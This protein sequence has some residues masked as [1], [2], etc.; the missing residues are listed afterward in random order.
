MNRMQNELYSLITGEYKE[1]ETELDLLSRRAF[2][3]ILRK[4]AKKLIKANG[5]PKLSPEQLRQVKEYY[6]GYPA[7]NPIYHQVNTGKSGRFYPEYIPEELYYGY[8]EPYFS[9][10]VETRYV[11]N[12][13][14]YYRMFAGF[15][16]PEL[17]CMR[18]RG[19]WFGADF[20]PVT[21]KE[22]LK[23][24]DT[25]AEVVLKRA[26][27]SEGGA[28]V[29]F[30]PVEHRLESFRKL[31]RTIPCDVVIQKVL[32]QHEAYA[33]LHPESVNTL[34][35]MS[36]LEPEGTRILACCVRIGVGKSRMDNSSSGGFFVG[37]HGDGSLGE[38]AIFDNGKKITRHP[39]LGYVI[40]AQRL[41]YIDRA[42]DF[43]R[44]AHL[45]IG[46][47]RLAAWDIA[48]DEEGEPNLIEVNLT[49]GAIDDVQACT[50]P[51]FGKDTKKVLKEVFGR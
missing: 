30:L 20:R 22:V 6:K 15:K 51:L 46:R 32:K 31:I 10:R 17:V 50:G 26:E 12:K 42:F 2:A 28:G 19:L 37:V 40:A 45:C 34:R 24:L 13:C 21:K 44:R 36:L 47:F 39:D 35:I 27:N 4:K 7:A 23:C 25:E 48:L 1:G 3:H 49:L 14:D 43:V 8:I 41:P 16:Q 9:G 33:G 29:H 38:L 5:Y 11:D 18:T